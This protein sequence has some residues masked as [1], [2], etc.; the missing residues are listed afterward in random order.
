[1]PQYCHQFVKLPE[2]WDLDAYFPQ[3]NYSVFISQGNRCATVNSRMVELVH[4]AIKPL[5]NFLNMQELVNIILRYAMV[6]ALV[7]VIC[8]YCVIKVKKFLVYIAIFDNY[9]K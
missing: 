1:M 5:N 3:L 2:L 4:L 6:T 7:R 8:Q 9:T